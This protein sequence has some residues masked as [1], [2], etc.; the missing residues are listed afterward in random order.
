MGCGRWT[1]GLALGCWVVIA[2]AG[3]V[4]LDDHR[5]LQAQN[6][7]LAAETEALAKELFDLRGGSGSLHVRITSMERELATQDE[8][9][10]NLRSENEIL[11]EMRKE[12]QAE[13]EAMANRQTLGAVVVAGP[14]LPQALDNQLKRFAGEHPGVVEYDS[15]SGRIKWKSDLLFALGSDVVKQ[16]SIT[17]LERFTSIVFHEGQASHKLASVG[18]PGDR[19]RDYSHEEWLPHRPHRSYGL[20]GISARHG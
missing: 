18:P 11:D 7:T 4:S 3:C 19:R 14:K 13:L 6:R 9:I 1:T 12:Y 16:S 5:K 20:W 17:A 10:A 8:F 2:S 15:A